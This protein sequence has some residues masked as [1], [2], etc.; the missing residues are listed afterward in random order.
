MGR[1]AGPSQIVR[2]V[3]VGHQPHLAIARTPA[4]CATSNRG[5][6]PREAA[7]CVWAHHTRFGAVSRATRLS[8]ASTRDTRPRTQMSIRSKFQAPAVDPDVFLAWG[9][10]AFIAFLGIT[11]VGFYAGAVSRVIIEQG[12]ITRATMDLSK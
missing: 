2:A 11:V 10:V 9:I 6:C 1:F 12:P 8:S 5:I 7:G 3:S 4:D